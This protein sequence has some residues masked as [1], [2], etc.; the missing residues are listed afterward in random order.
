MKVGILYDS[1]KF[2][3]VLRAE[4]NIEANEVVLKE[5]VPVLVASRD[6]S[7]STMR[8]PSRSQ[9]S[10]DDDQLNAEVETLYFL[11]VEAFARASR[12]V[13]RKILDTFYCPEETAFSDPELKRAYSI[14]SNR[15]R[16]VASFV[17]R[18][19]EDACRGLTLKELQHAALIFDLNAHRLRNTDVLYEYASKITHS[20]APNTNYDP[21]TGT[22]VALRRIQ[23]GE[24]ITSNYL[25]TNIFPTRYRRELLLKTKLFWC[26]CK[27]CEQGVDLPRAMPCPKCTKQK[28]DKD[29]MYDL[30]V[31]LESVPVSYVTCRG[32]AESSKWRCSNC[33]TAFDSNPLAPIDNVKDPERRLEILGL[34]MACNMRLKSKDAGDFFTY[35]LCLL[36]ARHW[37]PRHVQRA[38]L[39]ERLLQENE[40]TLKTREACHDGLNQLWNWIEN[41]T[42]GEARYELCDIVIMFLRRLTSQKYDLRGD[43]MLQI[44]EKRLELEDSFRSEYRKSNVVLWPL[45]I[46]VPVPRNVKVGKSF[47]L[48]PFQGLELKMCLLEQCHKDGDTFRVKIPKSVIDESKIAEVEAAYRV[49]EESE[50]KIVD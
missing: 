34:D 25:D 38:L 8:K 43:E 36:G 3:N 6:P 39:R 12:D 42:Y 10:T 16:R 22:F 26:Q 1:K 14:L 31:A 13:Q 40:F 32:F 30:S 20:C 19:N 41:H 29:G 37:I 46:D 15:A 50:A 33:R 5:D 27:R 47:V 49:W 11:H 48:R 21:K 35:S 44:W 18:F 7:K 45:I 2:G 4:C 17:S 23:T 28:R 24:L 9:I